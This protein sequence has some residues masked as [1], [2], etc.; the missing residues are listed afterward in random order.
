MSTI[1]FDLTTGKPLSPREQRKREQ[2]EK[3]GKQKGQ[4]RREA[5]KLSKAL[6][7]FKREIAWIG[8]FSLIANALLISPAI[9]NLQV[10]DRVMVYHNE[11]TLIVLT[12]ILLMLFGFM[13]TSE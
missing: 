6:W 13:A 3:A 12:G 10:Y 8:F 5:S 11:I 1:D 7:K 9:Y 2:A 4:R